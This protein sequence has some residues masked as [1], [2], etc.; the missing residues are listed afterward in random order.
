MPIAEICSFKPTPFIVA[1]EGECTGSPQKI[2]SHFCWQTCT[3]K[4]IQLSSSATPVMM[5]ALSVGWTKTKCSLTCIR[6]DVNHIVG[7]AKLSARTCIRNDVNHVANSPPCH[8][9]LT[10]KG[11][12]QKGLKLYLDLNKKLMLQAQPDWKLLDDEND[13]LAA[14]DSYDDHDDNDAHDAHDDLADDD[15]YDGDGGRRARL[16][17]T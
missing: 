13:D 9:F 10:L 12:I 8:C 1:R 6:N 2:S 17:A 14:D 3:F 16:E 7:R 11:V 5:M 15:N 4:H